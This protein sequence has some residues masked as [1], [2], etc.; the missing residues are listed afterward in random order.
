MANTLQFGGHLGGQLTGGGEHQDPG[1]LGPGR[2]TREPGHGPDAEGQGLARARRGLPQTSRPASAS[3]MVMDWMGKGSVIDL[4]SRAATMSTG[5]PREAKDG[6]KGGMRNF[7]AT[8][9]DAGMRLGGWPA[10][11]SAHQDAPH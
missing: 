10:A 11:N 2:P 8:G 5:T 1:V 3:G 6:C 4:R 7:R 9:M